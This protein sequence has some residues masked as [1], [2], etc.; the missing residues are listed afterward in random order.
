MT[1]YRVGIASAFGNPR[2]VDRPFVFE[3]QILI[4][5]WKRCPRGTNIVGMICSHPKSPSEEDPWA[6]RL[7]ENEGHQVRTKQIGLPQ[8][9][10]T[11][12]KIDLKLVHRGFVTDRL[13]DTGNFNLK[14]VVLWIVM[15]QPY[16]KKRKGPIPAWFRIRDREQFW[17]GQRAG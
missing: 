10:Q 1:E 13:F 11:R 16:D 9:K 12:V 8:N 5:I 2:E 7:R 15:R 17:N 6:I 14:S 4:G 3:V